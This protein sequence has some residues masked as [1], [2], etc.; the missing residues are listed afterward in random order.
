MNATILIIE[1]EPLQ[2]QVIRDALEAA[3]YNTLCASDGTE[4]LRLFYKHQPDLV[5]L[6]VVMPDLDGWEVCRRIRELSTVPII[7]ITVRGSHEDRV[8]GLKMG[9]DDYV[10]KP[11]VAE[12]LQARVEAVLRR[13]RMAPPG[14]RRVLHFRSGDLI[15]EPDSHEVI[16]WGEPVELTPTEYRLLIFMA[17][18]PN[19]VLSPDILADELWADDPEANVENVRWH[20][21]RLRQKIEADPDRP[22]LIVT[23]RGLGY[24][25]VA[26]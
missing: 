14:K 19:R 15:I 22:Q 20:I 26:T 10:V 6:D 24:R 23:E 4:G 21:W 12:E 5:I 3:E 7:F 13:I 25:F 8:K 18:R 11:F 17:E 2:L 9:A 16:V 1:D